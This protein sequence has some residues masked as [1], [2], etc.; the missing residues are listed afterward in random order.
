M[1][2]LLATD[3]GHDLSVLP[4]TAPA[5]D[6]V[7][8]DSGVMAVSLCIGDYFMTLLSGYNLSSAPILM[9]NVQNLMT[10]D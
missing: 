3:R 2:T 1:P 9:N 10:T 7:V 6:T 5:T 8:G 4:T